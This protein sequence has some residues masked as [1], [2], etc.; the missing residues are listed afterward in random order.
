MGRA[1]GASIGSLTQGKSKGG[2]TRGELLDDTI[3]C[4]IICSWPF[5]SGGGERFTD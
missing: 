3:Y 1:F 2:E 4:Q 5:Y